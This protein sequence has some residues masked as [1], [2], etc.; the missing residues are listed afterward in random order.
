MGTEE[1]KK[2]TNWK[3]ELLEWI[4]LL[5]CTVAAVVI[6]NSFIVVNARIP[7]GSMKDGIQEGDRIF[8]NRLAYLNSDPE[9]MDVIMFRYPDDRSQI[10]VKRIIGLPGETVTIVDGKVYINDSE[11]PLDDSFIPEPMKGSFGPY[12][13]PEGCY[14]VLG[15]NR[16]N[17]LDSRKWEN[18]Y[19]PRED[20]LGKAGFRYWPLNRIGFV[21]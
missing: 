9:R 7:S 10:F 19:V 16:N 18:T 17:S 15:D 8:A 21:K 4:V 2:E 3:K 12:E 14:F 20:I 11:T 5:G 1:P 13:V 6:F